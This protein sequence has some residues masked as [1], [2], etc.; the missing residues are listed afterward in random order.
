MLTGSRALK[1]FSA[2]HGVRVEQLCARFGEFA[3]FRRSA[4]LP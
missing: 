1:A 4:S 2:Q 3:R